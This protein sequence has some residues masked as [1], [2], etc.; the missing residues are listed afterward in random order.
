MLM[1]LNADIYTYVAVMPFYSVAQVL[2]E[3]WSEVA[4]GTSDSRINF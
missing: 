4:E 1:I 3:Q 2:F